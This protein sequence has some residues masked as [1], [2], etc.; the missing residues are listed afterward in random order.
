[1]SFNLDAGGLNSHSLDDLA[2][3]HL[4]H[5]CI[6]FKELCGTGQK[7]I[8]FNLVQLDKATEYAAE[9]ADVALAAL[10]AL[11]RAAAVRE[12][13]P[14]LRAGRPADGGG[15]RRRWSATASRS[16]ARCSRASRPSSTPRSPSSRRRIC[17]EA[18]CKFT[19]GSPQQLGDI[20][21]NKMGLSGGRKG[22][23][24]VYSTDQTELERLEREGVPIARLV[25]EW[26][27]LTKLKS[28]YTDALQEQI[29]RETGRVHTCY[30]PL[31]RADRAAGL[32]R[33]QPHEHPDPHRDRPADPRRLHRRAGPCHA[34]GRLQPDRASPRRPYVRR[35]DAEGGVRA[36]RG[37][38][39]P[40]RRGAVRQ[41]S[42][43]TPAPRPRRSTSPSSTASRAGASPSG[44]RSPPRRRRR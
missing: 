37:H 18:G 29:N 5:N 13:D 39:Q 33:P 28:T 31:R 27:Q 2:K 17:G 40:H 4:D 36:R 22:K 41:R 24:G 15:D 23:S 25:L 32:D 14:G 6:A 7:Q 19:I 12:G 34:L 16:T 42:T 3:K 10:A 9:D 30:S 38:P 21:F 11:P 44:W 8:T 20:L 43:A 1:M 35:A 26:R